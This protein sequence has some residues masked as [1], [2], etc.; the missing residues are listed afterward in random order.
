[1]FKKNRLKA[2]NLKLSK[3]TLIFDLPAMK[4]CPDSSKCHGTCY[5]RKGEWR[6]AVKAWRVENYKL[7][8]KP[9]K[10]FKLLY[11]QLSR[12]KKNAIRIHSSGDFFSQDYIDMWTDL[13]ISFPDKMF[14]AY[15]K[16]KKTFNFSTLEKSQN[17]N[18]LNSLVWGKLNYGSR[19]YVEN[20]AKKSG[21]FICP[22]GY[23]GEKITCG[24]ECKYC[25]TKGNTSAL[26]LQH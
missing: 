24:E 3:N 15:T 18:I 9:K 26:F 8:K 1:M 7:A 21:A 14:Y 16:A 17:V 10:L 12:T 11:S 13:A 2:G 19:K 20:L 6:P 23:S 4:T 5:A 25:L 22:H